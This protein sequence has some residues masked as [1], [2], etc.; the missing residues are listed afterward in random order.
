MKFCASVLTEEH[1]NVDTDS[2]RNGIKVLVI[3]SGFQRACTQGVLIVQDSPYPQQYTLP[4]WDKEKTQMY[5]HL[6]H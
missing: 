6:Y 4:N 2:K 5:L 3:L 1:G